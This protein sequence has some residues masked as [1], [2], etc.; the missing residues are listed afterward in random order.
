[1]PVLVLV[2]ASVPVHRFCINLITFGMRADE[3]NEHRP[4][5][6]VESG[7]YSIVVSPDVEDDPVSLYGAGGWVSC[8]NVLEI[9]P[10][11]RTKCPAQLPKRL[12]R[13]GMLPSKLDE[14]AAIEQTHDLIPSV[15]LP[16]AR[17]RVGSPTRPFSSGSPVCLS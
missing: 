6:V 15:F 1:M 8:R 13:A 11:R 5:P 16:G 9:R 14:R 12:F 17:T 10:A 2:T 4:S 3:L 7:D